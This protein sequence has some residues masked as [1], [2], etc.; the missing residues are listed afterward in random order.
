MAQCNSKNST[1]YEDLG[2]IHHDIDNSA[3]VGSR[4]K[5][6]RYEDDGLDLVE[7]ATLIRGPDPKTWRMYG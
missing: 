2:V 5:L 4:N 6:C 1:L 3:A 7:K